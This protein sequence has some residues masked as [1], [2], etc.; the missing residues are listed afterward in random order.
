MSSSGYCN[1]SHYCMLGINDR[2]LVES[3]IQCGVAR[4]KSMIL[5]FP[6][7]DAVPASLLNHFIRGYFDGD[8]SVYG[9][10]QSPC[11][12]F[13]GNE[14]FLAPLLE[15]IKQV[16]G[17]KANLQRDR[18]IWCIKLGGKNIIR[19]LYDYLY[20]NSTIY[21]SRKRTKFETMLDIPVDVQR[22]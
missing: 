12:S 9:N 15:I 10:S 5:T 18:S 11:A 20:T 2:H 16:T 7:D 22:L 8:G 14:T 4:R 19:R 21:L 3:L 17:T 13:D 6:S 1:E